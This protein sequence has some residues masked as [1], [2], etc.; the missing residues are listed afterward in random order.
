MK[1][2]HRCGYPLFAHFHDGTLDYLDD[3]AGS[4]S[5]ERVVQYCPGCG[6]LLAEVAILS[7]AEWAELQWRDALW[8]PP[9]ERVCCAPPGSAAR[10]FPL[11]G[12]FSW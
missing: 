2:R 11:Y 6:E 10:L 1:R 7:E 9:G 3:E 5:F 8:M 12:E 4:P